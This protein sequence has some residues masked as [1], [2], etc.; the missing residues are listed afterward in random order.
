MLEPLNDINPA[1]Q[2][3]SAQDNVYLTLADLDAI[4]G[5]GS[6]KQSGG[7]LFGMCCKGT[8]IRKVTIEAL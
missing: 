4:A 7:S 1:K 2:P 6:A 5:G 8:H 3:S